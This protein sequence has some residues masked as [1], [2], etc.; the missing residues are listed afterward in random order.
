MNNDFL[1]FKRGVKNEA[2]DVSSEYCIEILDADF[3]PLLGKVQL[4][5]QIRTLDYD[6]VGFILE[7]LDPLSSKFDD[8]LKL[9]LYPTECHQ[10]VK[11]KIHDFIG[12]RGFASL[13]YTGTSWSINW[14]SFDPEESGVSEL[15]EFYECNTI[16]A[17]KEVLI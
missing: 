12:L 15:N 8:V 4:F 10:I 5:V 9:M 16:P 11:I 14:D 17:G 1:F 3:S 13:S 2:F 7:E 6:H